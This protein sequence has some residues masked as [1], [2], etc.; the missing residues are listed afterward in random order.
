M[1]QQVRLFE[2]LI[3]MFEPSFKSPNITANFIDVA[4]FTKLN[5]AK[6]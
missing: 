4:I 2:T 1:K 3:S 6:V 5:Q